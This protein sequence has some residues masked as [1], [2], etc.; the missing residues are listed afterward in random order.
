[1]TEDDSLAN[2]DAP[3]DI[4][5]GLVFIFLI[6]TQEVVL[7]DI[8]QGH[9]LSAEFNDVGVRDD[10]L[11]KLQH[12]VLKEALCVNHY[13]C[14]IQHKHTDFLHIQK[15]ISITVLNITFTNNLVRLIH[16]FEFPILVNLPLRYRLLQLRLSLLQLLKQIN[17]ISRKIPYLT[18]LKC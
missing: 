13:I 15:L 16:K 17:S 6:L 1:M 8:G 7:P 14:F 4:A 9:L 11:S 18:F 2:S 12:G 10:L 5:Q 3:I